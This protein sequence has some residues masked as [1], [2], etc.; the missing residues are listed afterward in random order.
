MTEASNNLPGKT[1]DDDRKKVFLAA[2]SEFPHVNAAAKKAGVSF[3]TAYKYRHKDPDFAKAWD[4]ALDIGFNVLESEAVRRAVQGVEEPVFYKGDVVGSIT[5]HSDS[6]LMFMLKGRR[7][8]VYGDK[9]SE[10]SGD[11]SIT[12]R[13]VG[14]L[15]DA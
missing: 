13:V 8:E 1:F 12:I 15:P 5:K 11:K 14:G 6:L 2:L 7:R 4:I 3:V 9:A 10:D